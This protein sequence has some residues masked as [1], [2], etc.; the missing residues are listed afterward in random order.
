M[1][2]GRVITKK[3]P[4]IMVTETPSD[5]R[6]HKRREIIEKLA[7]EPK[8]KKLMKKLGYSMDPKTWI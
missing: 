1:G 2:I 5:F 6:W 3:L 4:L 7:K 8:V